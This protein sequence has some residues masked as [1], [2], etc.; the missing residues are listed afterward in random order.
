[1]MAL[2]P[3]D[4]ASDAL[5]QLQRAGHHGTRCATHRPRY[6]RG[7]DDRHRH[8]GCDPIR[9]TAW[10]TI[11]FGEEAGNTGQLYELIDPLDTTGVTLDRTTGVFSGGTNPQN[12]VR[13]DVAR[14][15]V[16]R[17]ARAACRAASC[18]T[19]TSCVPS[20]GKPGGAYYKFIPSDPVYGQRAD[21]RPRRLTARVGA[22]VRA[23]SRSPRTAAPT[24]DR[25]TARARARGF[26]SAATD[27]V[28]APCC[29]RRP[30]RVRRDQQDDRLLPARGPRGRPR[31]RC[32]RAM[33]SSAATTPATRQTTTSARPSASPTARSPSRAPTPATPSAALR[34][35][36]PAVRDDGQPR[37]P[38][39]PGNWIINEDGD[40][41]HGQQRHLGLPARRHRRR[42]AERRMCP[43]RDAQRPHGGDHRRHLR[44]HGRRTT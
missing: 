13:R 32:R 29:E 2:W 23:R 44:R 14:P 4:C 40:Q 39:R 26:R 9:R 1:M 5:D 28:P 36:E 17:R 35:R 19:A 11:V 34:A 24:S 20:N 41:L 25:A 43:D 16:V 37:L 27:A 33:F 38:A 22:G 3:N 30:R 31:S 6:R 21:H 42:P 7:R 12:L 18:T 8:D 15:P 10:G